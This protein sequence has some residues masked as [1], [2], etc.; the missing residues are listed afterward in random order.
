MTRI[1][2]GKWWHWGLLVVV[3]VLLWLAGERRLHVV[4]FNTFVL[5]LLVGVALVVVAVLARTKPGEQVTRDRLE[6][7]E[8]S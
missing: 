1:F 2:L 8:E 4:E 6:P 5:A 3:T 7:P